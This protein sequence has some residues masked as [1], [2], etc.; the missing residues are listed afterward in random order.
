M[1][2]R[3]VVH[4]GEAAESPTSFAEPTPKRQR[5]FIARQVSC[6][7]CRK[8]KSRCDGDSPCNTCRVAGNECV[9]ADRK[10]TKNEVSLG[11]IFSTLQRIE[12]KVNNVAVSAISPSSVASQPERLGIPLLEEHGASPASPESNTVTTHSPA[13][14]YAIRRVVAWPAVQ[15]MLQPCHQNHN[16]E[17]ATV[18]EHSREPLWHGPPLLPH[19]QDIVA[20]LSIS[21]VRNL[22]DDYFSTFNLAN[23]VLDR[24][25]FSQQ[26]LGTAIS[27]EFGNNIESCL[28]LVVM[29]LGCFGARALREGDFEVP[30]QDRASQA[31]EVGWQDG[32]PGLAFFNEARKRIGYIMCEN[33]MQACQFYLLSGLVYAQL[34]RPSEWWNMVNRAGVCCMTFWE[35]AKTETCDEWV[36]D[37]Q[38]RLYWH[39]VMCEAVLTQELDF[40]VS[41]LSEYEE[42]VPLP[43]FVQFHSSQHWMNSSTAKHP[44]SDQ[45]SLCQYH[46][47]AQIAH[48]IIL[49]RM[50]HSIFSQQRSNVTVHTSSSPRTSLHH[51][52]PTSRIDYAPQALEDEILHQLEQWRQQLPLALQFEDDDIVP[53]STSITNVL[54]EPWLRS[55]Y[56]IA[57]YHLRRPLLHRALHYP[58]SLTANDLDKCRHAI[59][60][61]MSWTRLMQ[62]SL[63]TKSCLPLSFFI[64]TQLFGQLLILS[65][66]HSSR[67]PQL[68]DLV[69]AD[70]ETW[71]AFALGYLR[72]CA[73]SSP[74]IAREY[75]I[76][77]TLPV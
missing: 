24:A 10:A 17:S 41:R 64:A 47:L 46:F 70:F 55:R 74:T 48:R 45:T 56:M 53:P 67:H 30:N 15:N 44:V 12:H 69:P 6:E 25:M 8:K 11:V 60:A 20:T 5:L 43:R 13:I 28:V 9:F 52:M 3:A 51:L 7:T 1:D 50:H 2:L 63:V 76:A 75:D 61:I 36:R 19:S 31:A 21:I 33:S 62:L 14:S 42:Q 34:M 29:T 72:E 77:A 16:T 23:P 66:L 39:T 57:K 54:V 18:M 73:A 68:I 71:R 27:T 22:S 37:M 32:I 58:D 40:P 35:R 26:T 59:G 38:S 4:T 49:T 65:A